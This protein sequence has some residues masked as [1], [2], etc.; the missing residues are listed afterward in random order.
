MGV[1]HAPGPVKHNPGAGTIEEGAGDYDSEPDCP[2]AA[3][4][5]GD[6]DRSENYTRT[7]EC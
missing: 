5:A 4:L 6:C 2:D 7:V 1:R 3:Y